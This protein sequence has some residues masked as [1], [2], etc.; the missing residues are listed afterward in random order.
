[1]CFSKLFKPKEETYP[2]YTGRTALLFAINDY[3]GSASDLRGCINDQ[4]NIHETL[5]KKHYPEFTVLKYKN[6]EVK[7]WRM[8]N[9]LRH[10]VALLQPGDFLFIHYSGHGTQGVDPFHVEADGYS[11]ALYLHDGPLWDYEISDILMGIPEGAKVVVA[12]DSCYSGG[13]GHRLK[14]DKEIRNR[15]TPIQDIKPE[16]Q[17]R[18]HMLREYKAR[19][20]LFAGSQECQL[21]ADALIDGQYV[22]AFTY[23]WL[24]SFMPTITYNQ[25]LTRTR[26][27]LSQFPE[28]DQV[29]M[30]IGE[31]DLISQIVFT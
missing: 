25:W 24:M 26:F 28:F 29:P 1:M 21:S 2:E 15:Y 27:A 16:V 20:I 3:P 18:K 7:T 13:S 9:V 14:N 5:F 12:F 4:E 19:F 23:F 22:G 6:R 30:I 17:L 31:Q 8:R 11:E 10:Y